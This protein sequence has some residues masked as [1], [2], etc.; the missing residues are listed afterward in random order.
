MQT[1]K[2]VL[3][4]ANPTESLSVI[5]KSVENLRTDVTAELCLL[6]K[7]SIPVVILKPTSPSKLQIIY[8]FSALGADE[9]GNMCRGFSVVAS[10]DDRPS[11][12]IEMIGTA[13]TLQ[14]IRDL[15]DWRPNQ[16]IDSMTRSRLDMFGDVRS[17]Y[18]VPYQCEEDECCGTSNRCVQHLSSVV[19]D[20]TVLDVKQISDSPDSPT[21]IWC[22]TI[23]SFDSDSESITVESVELDSFQDVLCVIEQISATAFCQTAPQVVSTLQNFSSCA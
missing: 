12:S 1:L 20:K 5:A 23:H 4:R 13:A 22:L 8:V 11:L 16:A 18:S 15:L 9:S 3:P 21:K 2:T 19:L 10:F 6:E 7:G 14:I 17:S